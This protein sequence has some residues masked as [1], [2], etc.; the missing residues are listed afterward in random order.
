MFWS[1]YTKLEALMP[2]YITEEFVSIERG[3]Y[4]TFQRHIIPVK[5]LEEVMKK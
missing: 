3:V 5:F 2:Y 1:S 4:I